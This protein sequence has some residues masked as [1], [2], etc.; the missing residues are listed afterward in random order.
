[1]NSALF[2]DRDGVINIDFG[3]VHT[4]EKFI[5]NEGIFD[6]VASANAKGYLVIIVTNQAGIGKGFYTERDFNIL[7]EWMLGKFIDH[8]GKIDKIFFCPFHEDATIKKYKQKSFDR[9]PAPGMIQKAC[10][11]FNIDPKL[12]I[13]VG[14]KISDIQAGISSNIDKT[15]YYGEDTCN[16]AYKSVS[17]LLDIKEELIF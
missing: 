8:G 10:K 1:V 11:E 17:R 12:S 15:I 4:K 14:D 9:K 16:L 13:I 6:L 2:L 5:F 3:Y 7:T